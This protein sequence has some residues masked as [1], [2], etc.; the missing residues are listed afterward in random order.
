M[1]LFILKN[2]LFCLPGVVLGFV[3]HKRQSELKLF[4]GLTP[5]SILFMLLTDVNRGAV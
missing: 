1:N 3:L 2:R 4:L 5:R